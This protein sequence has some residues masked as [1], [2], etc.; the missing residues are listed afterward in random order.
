MADI[1]TMFVLLCGGGVLYAA[2]RVLY[3]IFLHPL[4]RYP[5]PMLWKAIRLTWIVALQRGYLH[6]DLLRLHDQYGP[7][8]RIAPN[9]L[10]YIDAQAW[11]DIY[12]SRLGH[13]VLE[14]NPVWF[15][16]KPAEPWSI[17]GY[18]EDAHAR[19]RRAFMGSFSEKAVKDQSPLLEKYVEMM[20]QRFK[21]MAV[22]ASA[23]VDVV[24][25]LN[26][27]TFDISADLSF[28]ES[29]ESTS[30]GEPHPWVEI[31]C[32]FGKGVALVASINHYGPLES[33]LRM[34]LPK[35]VREKMICH[36]ELTA[37]MVRK[38]LQL[39]DERADFV[40]AVLK[41]NQ[42]KTD[43]V[44]A[45][46]LELN[47]SVIVFAGSETT[48]TAM[49]SALFYL[50]Q[51]PAARERVTVEV[52]TAFKHEEDIDVNSS[53]KLEYLSAI[54]NEAMRLGPPSAI[55]VP[56]VVSEGGE[57]ICGRWVPG[58]TFVGV[59][60]YPAFRSATNFSDPEAFIPERFLDKQSPD[61][62]LAVFQPFSVG[63][64]MCIGQKFA[65]AEM[66]LI[67]ARLLYAFDLSWDVAPTI[68]DWGEQQTFIFWQKEPLQIKLK[69]RDD[70]NVV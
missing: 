57:E 41:Y 37:Q 46:E 33:L 43:K 7:V 25:W 5:G 22:G 26:F 19:F 10:S 58:G 3:N 6:Q 42:E 51:T 61:D 62:N 60:Q 17:M 35:K 48:S 16:K 67:L 2:L 18:D 28:G 59:N 12:T 27:V 30:K 39:Q 31:A 15:R 63:R 36:R 64:H 1:R 23:T 29:F 44:T 9:E 4:R 69:R 47:M 56:R 66:R 21:Q 34:A 24:S 13:A 38:R 45:E 20:V 32:R 54:I 53:S 55:G 49:A 8:V 50:L 40:N 68:D 52:R 65:W 70:T 14:R 11:K